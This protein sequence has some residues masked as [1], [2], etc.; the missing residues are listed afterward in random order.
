M[1]KKKINKQILFFY[2][3]VVLYH[4]HY[5]AEAKYVNELIKFEDTDQTV[6]LLPLKYRG[7]SLK[8]DL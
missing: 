5:T 7:A 2:I 6:I 3:Y 1:V 4:I 8:E